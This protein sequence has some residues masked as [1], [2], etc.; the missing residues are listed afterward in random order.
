MKF[1]HFFL[2]CVSF[3]SFRIRIQPDNI[4]ADPCG[5]GSLSGFITAA[6]Y[7]SPPEGSCY[8]ITEIQKKTTVLVRYTVK[9]DLRSSRPQP[10]RHLL[11]SPWPGIRQLFPAS[12]SMVGDIPAGDGKIVNLF[13]SEPQLWWTKRVQLYVYILL[14]CTERVRL[15]TSCPCS[16]RGGLCTI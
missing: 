10:G 15:P 16:G 1:L 14:K 13:Y 9:K 3:L 8:L 6:F 5:S 7:S 2:F 11:N 4:N 12:E